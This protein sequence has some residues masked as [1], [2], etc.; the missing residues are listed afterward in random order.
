MSAGLKPITRA[1]ADHVG[2]PTGATAEAV[3]A[4]AGT[5]RVNG[6]RAAKD[7]P[8]AAKANAIAHR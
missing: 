2:S 8:A 5:S 1:Q 6:T 4:S 3:E 7:S